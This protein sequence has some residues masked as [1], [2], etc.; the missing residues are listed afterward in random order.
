MVKK[1]QILGDGRVVQTFFRGEIRFVAGTVGRTWLLDSSGLECECCSAIYQLY[2]VL[3]L[4]GV[5]FLICKTEIKVPTSWEFP[6]G[7]VVRTQYCRCGSLGSTPGWG[8]KI[9]QAAQHS[10]EKK[11]CLLLKSVV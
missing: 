4:S 5:H 10:Q 9:P 3:A 2:I 1:P 6:G 11:M 8:T 7:P